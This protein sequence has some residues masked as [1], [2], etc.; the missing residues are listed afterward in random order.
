MRNAGGWERRCAEEGLAPVEKEETAEVAEAGEEVRKQ[1]EGEVVEV[2]GVVETAGGLLTVQGVEVGEVEVEIHKAEVVEELQRVEE[3]L[4]EVEVPRTG[5]VLMEVEVGEG[6]L[7][8]H[9]V[10][11][12]V[13]VVAVEGVE[14][15]KPE[16]AVVEVV[17]GCL[18]VTEWEGVALGLPR[19]E[20]VHPQAMVEVGGEEKVEA[21]EELLPKKEGG[22]R[23][24]EGEV[25]E[26]VANQ[27]KEGVQ[28]ASVKEQGVG[29]TV[30]VEVVEEDR[31]HA[32]QTQTALQATLSALSMASVSVHLTNP[33]VRT[34]GDR[35]E[36]EEEQVVAVAKE[37]EVVELGVVEEEVEEKGHAHLTATAPLKT[38]LALSGVSASVPPTNQEEV[39]VGE[40]VEVSTTGNAVRMRIVRPLTQLVPSGDSVNALSISLVILTVTLA[41]GNN[42]GSALS[43]QHMGPDCY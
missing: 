38:P 30:E 15:H 9:R 11:V 1:V 5:E 17:E 42:I 40:E 20:E 36:V 18:K 41:P 32:H 3:V 28:E 16:E 29:E 10:E 33:E 39:T 37:V 43:F 12:G 4:V 6:V 8:L 25:R 7:R 2:G 13:C 26:E 31:V 23:K 14:I 24:V 22:K 19:V 34:V 27:R 35:V 21:R